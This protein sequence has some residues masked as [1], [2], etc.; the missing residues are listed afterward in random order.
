MSEVSSDKF[1]QFTSSSGL[2]ED[3]FLTMNQ[4]R[5][6][7]INRIVPD[8]KL[9]DWKS[10][11]ETN[12][13]TPMMEKVRHLMKR[14]DSFDVVVVI[15]E[16]AFDC[17]MLTLQCY[18][19][20]FQ[21]LSRHDGDIILPVSKITPTV[22][23]KIY[24]WMIKSTKM[25]ER[26]DLIPLLMGAQYL[27]VTQMEQQI[28]NLIQDGAKFQEAEAF[29][30]YLEAKMWGCDKVKDMMV[31]RVHRF[32]LTAVST[33]DFLLMDASEV[34][35]WLKAN[36]IG[37]NSEVEAFYV[38]AR[39]LLHD[40]DERKIHLTTLMK[41]VRFGLVEPW[42]IVDFRRNS[43]M[44]KLTVILNNKELQDLL[45]ASMSYSVYRSSFKDDSSPHFQNFLQR[46]G[47]ERLYPRDSPEPT[48]TFG[49][50]AY[51]FDEFEDYLSRL[52]AEAFTVW[53]K[54]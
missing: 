43:N 8:P 14:P 32:F 44:N 46:F 37:I 53:N 39:W 48:W 15:G 26:E 50:S 47:F 36:S 30:L 40:W 54:R 38:A 4:E 21:R 2:S 27:G 5:V 29:L 52:R 17:F 34:R 19:K 33:E 23:H 24:E 20:H 41:T 7:A 10:Y 49:S 18:S 35:N 16:D 51:S 42:R 45:E 28:W 11:P 31:N 6:Y 22:F 3:Y 12:K 13:K 9:N 1:S 25:I